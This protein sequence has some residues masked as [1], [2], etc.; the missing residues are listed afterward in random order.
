VPPIP[1]Q[2]VEIKIAKIIMNEIHDGSTL[3]FGIG[4]LPN[5]IGKM[6]AESDLKDLLSIQR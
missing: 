1:E 3:Q 5:V 2:E 4:G 6:I